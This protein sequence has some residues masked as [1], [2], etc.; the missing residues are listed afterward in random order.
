MIAVK[1]ENGIIVSRVSTNAL[2]ENYEVDTKGHSYTGARRA[3][4]DAEW[5][6]KPLS[7]LVAEGVVEVP[8][9]YKL[10]GEAFVAMS[11]V[12]LVEAGIH[13]LPKYQKIVDGEIVEKT[14][15]EQYEDGAITAKEYNAYI[16]MCRKAAYANETDALFWDYQEGTITKDAWLE[17]KKA[18]KAKYE[19]V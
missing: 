13:V 7:T 5:N 4:F 17:A 3:E 1:I 19:K 11:E 14:M 10:E 15:L 12:E 18:V 8:V 16:V 6:V 2:P 9:G